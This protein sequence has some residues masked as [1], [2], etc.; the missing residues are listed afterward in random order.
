MLNQN[1]ILEFQQQFYKNDIIHLNNAGLQPIAKVAHDKINYWAD[2][3]YKEG[4]LT[5]RDYMSDVAHTR[6]Q[7]S[8]L[9]GCDSHEIAFFTSTASAINQVAFSVGLQAGDEVLMFEQEYASH[10]YPWKAACDEF[11]ARLVLVESEFNYQLSSEKL[12]SKMNS[13]TKV[14]ALSWVQFISG[15]RLTDLDDVIAYAKSK[16]IFVFLDVMQGLGLHQFDLWS[17]NLNT[18]PD[19]IMGGSH[20]WLVSPVGVGF[21]AIKNSLILKMKPRNIGAYTYGTCDDPSDFACEPKRD[22]TKFE[23]GSKQV[24][25]ITALGASIAMLLDIGL[26]NIE[27]ETLRLAKKL[28]K[29]LHHLGYEVI[30]PFTKVIE[31]EIDTEIVNSTPFIN[32]KFSQR[33]QNKW[34]DI[35]TCSRHLNSQKILHAIRGPG[36]RM[37]TQAFNTDQEIEKV[38]DVL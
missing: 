37:T 25:E 29:G 7:L 3:F 34:P 19:A 14:I 21:L 12:I 17:K 31:D 23:P 1:K 8:R 32:F 38:L 28:R 6:L 27:N 9:I 36:L 30:S 13:K 10:L 18:G 24:L 15:A 22:A 5:D 26:K 11:S 20:K 2:R 35:Q 4:F 16:N 33:Q